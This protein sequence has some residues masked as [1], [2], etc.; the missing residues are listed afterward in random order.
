[1]K[2]NSLSDYFVSLFQESFFAFV[3]GLKRL[4]FFKRK[5]TP[6]LLCYNIDW[7]TNCGWVEQ[8]IAFD[9]I[10]YYFDNKLTN[11]TEQN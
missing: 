10:S 8:L 3:D 9:R 6:S 11:Y 1:M 2:T 7:F 5:V 4:N